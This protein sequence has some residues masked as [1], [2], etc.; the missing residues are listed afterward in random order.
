M[1]TALRRKL[2]IV[3]D[4]ACGKTSLFSTFINGTFPEEHVPTVFHEYSHVVDM[5][6]DGKH[7]ELALWDTA[8]HE[9]DN[10]LRPLSYPDSNVVLICF[11]IDSPDSLHN[12]W[13]K[14]IDESL[15]FN[16]N[17]PHIL[18]GLKKDLR[19]DPQTIKEL[20]KA[21][22]RP[23]TTEQGEKICKQIGAEVYLECSACTSEGVREVF[24]IATRH[25]ATHRRKLCAKPCLIL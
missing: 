17:V 20:Y 23:V 12:V 11:A 2:V 24:E 9:D 14:W 15:H 4:S 21:Y 8:C 25:A 16:P 13:K 6:I 3:G 22:Q 19:H 5:N 18:V 10:R 1:A 7:I